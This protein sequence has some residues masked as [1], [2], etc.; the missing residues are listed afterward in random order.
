V[1]FT[2]VL[3]V[4]F[5]LPISDAFQQI[6]TFAAIRAAGLRAGFA[7][8]VPA[9]TAGAP[10]VATSSRTSAGFPAT[11]SCRPAIAVDFTPTASL[12]AACACSTG[13]LVAVFICQA[14]AAFLRLYDRL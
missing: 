4:L 13:E 14:A 5:P 3:V 1:P 7:S 12:Q 9:H 10:G 6:A 8:E 11:A 2:T